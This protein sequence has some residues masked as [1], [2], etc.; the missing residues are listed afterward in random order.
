VVA[1]STVS[2]AAGADEARNVTQL[3]L[4]TWQ[5]HFGRYNP[6]PEGTMTSSG[7]GWIASWVGATIFVSIQKTD[8][9]RAFE[10]EQFR[11]RIEATLDWR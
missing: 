7:W 9:G 4:K 8:G 6:G 11:F 1:Y 5:L 3:A 2:I 10:F